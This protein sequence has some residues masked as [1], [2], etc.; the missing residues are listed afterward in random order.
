MIF[1]LNGK[2]NKMRSPSFLSGPKIRKAL[3]EASNP[4]KLLH[5]LPLKSDFRWVVK[6][7]FL[8][9]KPQSRLHEFLVQIRVIAI[10]FYC[11]YL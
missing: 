2:G 4:K 6:V 1:F 8:D 5:R 3:F 10:S 7:K 11:L 9:M